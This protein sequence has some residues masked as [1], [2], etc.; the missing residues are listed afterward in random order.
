MCICCSVNKT[1]S[2]LSAALNN[3]MTVSN[4]LERIWKDVVV[5]YIMVIPWHL[6]GGL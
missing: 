6:L 3:W 5:T 2:N 4:K 1:L